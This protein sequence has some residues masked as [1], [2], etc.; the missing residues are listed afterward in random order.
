ML[1]SKDFRRIALGMKGAI[2]SAHM[3]HPDFRINNRIFST[4]HHDADYGMVKLTPDEQRAFMRAHPSA[5]TP[6]SGAWGLQGCTRVRIDAVD[7]DTLGEAMTLAWRAA[8][9]KPPS[10]SSRTTTISKAGT[11]KAVT[12]KRPKAGAGTSRTFADLV[13]SYPRDV[14]VLARATRALMLELLP[15]VEETVDPSGPYLT[16]GYGPGYKGVVSY[17]TINQKGVKLGI[18]GGSA[19]PDPRKLLQGT[20]KSH[21]HVVIETAADLR[22]PGLR[23]LVRAALAAWKKDRA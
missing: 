1:S 18:A 13:A 6:E 21:R 19:L 7:E 16:Y 3:G 23:P 22:T 2:E 15:Q 5:F 14:Q 12:L 10:R 8:S 9:A 4:L 20:G 11:K 17:L